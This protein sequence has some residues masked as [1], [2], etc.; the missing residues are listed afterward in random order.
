MS[1]DKIQ[2]A[3]EFILDRQ[4]KTEAEIAE[5][6]EMMANTDKKIAELAEQAELD[7]QYLREFAGEMRE[8]AGEMRNSINKLVDV[9]ENTR[10]FVQQVARLAIAT[11]KR[12]SKW[13]E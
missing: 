7:R 3:M 10:D 6:R 12:V 13:E 5:L 1:E 2:R 9:V 4:A 11:E 8:F